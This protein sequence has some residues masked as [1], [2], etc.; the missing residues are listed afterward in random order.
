[1]VP[2]E[3]ELKGIREAAF[4][5]FSILFDVNAQDIIK[6]GTTVSVSRAGV[7][8]SP[9]LSFLTTLIEVENK[10]RSNLYSLGV[11]GSRDFTAHQLWQT[12]LIHS[13]VSNDFIQAFI[14]ANEI[15]DTLVLLP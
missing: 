7:T 4:W 12:F 13:W 3:R 11:I 1:M 9:K 2:G 14:K 6:S 5:A 15:R 8:N 10:L